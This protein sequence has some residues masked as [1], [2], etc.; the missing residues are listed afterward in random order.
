MADNSLTYKE[1]ATLLC[2]IKAVLNSRPLY[3]AN[4][5]T[6]SLSDRLAGLL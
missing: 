3:T 6:R 4:T 5:D 2:H 1:M